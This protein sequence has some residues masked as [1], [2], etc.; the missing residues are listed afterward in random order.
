MLPD[1]HR[2]VAVAT[3][4]R[5]HGCVGCAPHGDA[6][7]GGIL[8]A[9]NPRPYEDGWRVFYTGQ[10]GDNVTHEIVP[11]PNTPRGEHWRARDEDD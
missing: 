11:N 9:K 1:R 3:S 6:S 8:G 5:H 7:I 10:H 4:C 2:S